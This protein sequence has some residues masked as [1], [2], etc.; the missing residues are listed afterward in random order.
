MRRRLTERDLS[1]IV[2]RV[3]NESS[4]GELSG[5]DPQ[6]PKECTEN[7]LKSY[8]MAMS[9]INNK[10]VKIQTGSDYGLDGIGGSIGNKI[11]VIT[12]Y[13]GKVCGCLKEKFFAGGI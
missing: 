11:L 8:M 7:Q 10:K 12:G 1:R 2:R 4:Y 3:I 13:D 6:L 9:E 5:S